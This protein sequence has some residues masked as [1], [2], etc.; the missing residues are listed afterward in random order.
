MAARA[1]RAPRPRKPAHRLEGLY[2]IRF[3]KKRKVKDAFQIRE[4]LADVQLLMIQPYDPA[5]GEP[6]DAAQLMPTSELPYVDLYDDERA[7]R[8]AQVAARRGTAP[9]SRER[10]SDA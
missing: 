5:T 4:V 9:R 1:T 7:W 10:G 8:D 2:G 6:F 3:S